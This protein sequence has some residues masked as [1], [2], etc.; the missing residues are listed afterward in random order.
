MEFRAKEQSRIVESRFLK[1]EPEILRG[2]GVKFSPDVSNKAGCP[3]YSL[4]QAVAKMDFQ[5]VYERTEWRN[6]AV[7]ARIKES[8]KYEILV[9]SSVP[10]KLISGLD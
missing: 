6:P 8:K 2:E 9:P 1:I 3:V 7:Q 10:L 5:V 4:E